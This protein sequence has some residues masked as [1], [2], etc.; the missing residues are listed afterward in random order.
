[1]L[2]PVRE[3]GGDDSGEGAR[4]GEP[5]DGEQFNQDLMVDLDGNLKQR[6]FFFWPDML[7]VASIAKQ[8]FPVDDPISH[9]ARPRTLL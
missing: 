7:L 6:K 5:D 2:C 9:R 4:D 1:M 3:G 8:V